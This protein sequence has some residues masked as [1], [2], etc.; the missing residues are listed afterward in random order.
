MSA[1]LDFGL[2]R[3][4]VYTRNGFSR[5]TNS[6]IIH[7]PATSRIV[8]VYLLDIR[9]W[10]AAAT[11]PGWYALEGVNPGVLVISNRPCETKC[12]YPCSSSYTVCVCDGFI[13]VS[14]KAR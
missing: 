13:L 11:P 9:P 6:W 12:V 8:L 2:T 1:R 14:V 5:P 7:R 3:Y 10:K 4:S